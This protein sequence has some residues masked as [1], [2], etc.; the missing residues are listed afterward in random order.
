[1]VVDQLLPW[2]AQEKGLFKKYGLNVDLK[3]IE[4]NAGVPALISGQTQVAFIG[5]SEVLSAAVEG[6]DLKMVG[7]LA[8]V[9]AFEFMASKGVNTPEDLRGK[10]VGVSKFGSTSDIA[11]RVALQKIGLVPGK[12]VEIVQVGSQ[13]NR[14]AAVAS[15][16]IQG[17]V[18]LYPDVGKLE[19]QGFHIL[20]D[21]ASLGIP[22]SSAGIA[23]N[24]A[25]ERSH[26]DEV[27][28]IVNA[29]IEAG[30]VERTDK[31]FAKKVIKD[32]TKT[33]DDDLVNI[34]YEY[35]VTKVH[36]KI[37]SVEPAQFQ[38]TMDRLAKGNEKVKS[39]DLK[40][41]LDNSY[42]DKAQ[43]S[44]LVEKLYGKQ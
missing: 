31:E 41:F 32:Y 18:T 16:A 34:T 35:Y 37:P 23:V 13:A 11:T 24:G 29:I 14:T 6:A 17:A 43:Q 26:P 39:F 9:F 40:K 36:P 33:S 7:T 38:E 21:L 28:A 10:R 1:M 2:I 25:W 12:D 8:P 5:G 22:A 44:G 4:S 27:Q 19:K 42:I 15:G 30:Y 20:F 3:L